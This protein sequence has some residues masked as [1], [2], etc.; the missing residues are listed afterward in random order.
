M[1]KHESRPVF[2]NG[3]YI[4]PIPISAGGHKDWPFQPYP[5]MLYKAESA[6]G[7]PRICGTKVVEDEAQERMA[8]G[9][10]WSDGQEAALERV[11]AQQLEFAKLAANRAYNEQWMSPKAKAEAAAVDETTMQHLPAIPET[12][13]RRKRKYERKA[14]PSKT[15][16]G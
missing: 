6:D 10:G 9:S 4:E 3:T 2:L 11:E 7:G 14:K 12:P 16:E 5:K 13:I 1:A 15:A 8:I